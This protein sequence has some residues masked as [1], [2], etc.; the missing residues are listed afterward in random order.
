MEDRDTGGE[1]TETRTCLDVTVEAVARATAQARALASL[2]QAAAA[3]GA[4]PAVRLGFE[5]L[6]GE[7]P[8]ARRGLRGGRGVPPVDEGAGAGEGGQCPARL[9][10]ERHGG[11]AA[12]R[13]HRRLG[14]NAQRRHAPVMLVRLLLA[15]AGQAVAV[16]VV[17]VLV[18]D[19][20]AVAGASR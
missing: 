15:A 7:A 2:L 9:H 8:E 16:A 5:P 12:G 18:L 1:T 19:C 6:R 17:A 13:R 4:A 11:V 10:L 20:L 3:P 14:L